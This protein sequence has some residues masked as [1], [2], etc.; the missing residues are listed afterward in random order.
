MAPALSFHDR[1][2]A[3]EFQVDEMLE[4]G[5]VAQHREALDRLEAIQAE[6]D[7]ATARVTRVSL[8][9]ARA[10]IARW[11]ILNGTYERAVTTSERRRKQAEL[12]DWAEHCMR[13]K[14]NI[15]LAEWRNSR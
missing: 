10:N 15:T 8:P 4:Y 14:S 11:H 3:A 2:K 13:T 1:L 9:E 5:T 12:F 6:R 7:G